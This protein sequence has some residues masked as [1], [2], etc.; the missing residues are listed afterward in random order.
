MAT[1]RRFCN[2]NKATVDLRYVFQLLAYI[3]HMICFRIRIGT[4]N[5]NDKMPTQDLSSWVR[6]GLANVTKKAIPPSKKISPLWLGEFEKENKKG[7]SFSF[8]VDLS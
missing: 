4:L 8:L 3:M 2:K 1:A 7:F 6:V 5:V